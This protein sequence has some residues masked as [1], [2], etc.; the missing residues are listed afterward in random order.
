MGRR[1]KP[2]PLVN[3]M[4]GVRV[5][6]NEYVFQKGR[7]FRVDEDGRDPVDVTKESPDVFNRLKQWETQFLKS[8]KRDRAYYYRKPQK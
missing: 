2:I 3:G 5:I 6:D 4:K 1:S 7:I 8:V